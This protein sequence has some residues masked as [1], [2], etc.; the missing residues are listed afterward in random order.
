MRHTILGVLL[1][2]NKDKDSNDE[3]RAYTNAL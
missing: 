2:A 3:H 1:Y